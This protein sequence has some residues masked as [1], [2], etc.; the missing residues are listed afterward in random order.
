MCVFLTI[1]G[2]PVLTVLN[3]I[4]TILALLC[5]LKQLDFKSYKYSLLSNV[6][7]KQVFHTVLESK[8]R[9]RFV[10]KEVFQV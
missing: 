8:E 10:L 2:K 6:L 7:K 9:L 4:K 5:C 1:F 3:M